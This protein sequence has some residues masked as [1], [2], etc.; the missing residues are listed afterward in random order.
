MDTRYVCFSK[1]GRG[2]VFMIAPEPAR[3]HC[4]PCRFPRRPVMLRIMT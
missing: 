2:Q 1:T 4:R 3:R